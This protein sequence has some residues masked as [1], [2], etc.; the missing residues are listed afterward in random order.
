MKL[1]L[2]TMVVLALCSCGKEGYSEGDRYGVINK[3]S[4]K[5]FFCKSWEGEMTLEGFQQTGQGGVAANLW[6]FSVRP[7]DELG[8]V[9]KLQQAAA[10]GKRVKIHYHQAYLVPLCETETEYFAKDVEVVQ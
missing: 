7:N 5:G 4:H 6:Q 8:I 3:F 2:L 10:S 9:E 1:A